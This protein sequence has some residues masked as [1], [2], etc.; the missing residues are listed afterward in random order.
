MKFIDADRSLQGA[1][2]R[3]FVTQRPQESDGQMLRGKM[4]EILAD[5]RVDRSFGDTCKETGERL[6]RLLGLGCPPHQPAVK[7]A[8]QAILSQ[9]RTGQ[10]ANEWYE[11][12]GA[13]NVYPLHALCLLGISEEPEVP[14]SLRWLAE[15]PEV[16]LGPDQG[17]PWTPI[18]FLKAIWAG[19]GIEDM[20]ATLAKGLRWIADNLNDAGCLS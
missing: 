2:V 20:D 6:L 10:N 4:D 7:R 13:F 15:H 11:H 18:V 1:M 8:V 3:T 5:Q 14:S 16:W 9:K 12:E 19:R 17:C